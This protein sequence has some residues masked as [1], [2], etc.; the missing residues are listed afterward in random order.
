[1]T[2]I[3]RIG[4]GMLGFLA[5][6]LTVVLGVFR[7]ELSTAYW[8]LGQFDQASEQT[9]ILSSPDSHVHRHVLDGSLTSTIVALQWMLES[10]SFL[11]LAEVEP[12]TWQLRQFILAS[13]QSRFI[14]NHNP[15]S[16]PNSQLLP[17][18]ITD[19]PQ[20]EQYAMI[21]NHNEGQ[22][23]Y[24]L[25]YDG[26]NLERLTPYHDT[27]SPSFVWSSD[28]D[29]LT[30]TATDVQNPPHAIYRQ[31]MD[32][33][34]H[35]ELMRYRGEKRRLIISAETDTI[36]VGHYGSGFDSFDWSAPRLI[37]RISPALSESNLVTPEGDR[38]NVYGQ[39]SQDWIILEK[40]T[41]GGVRENFYRIST[42]GDELAP[43]L[44]N[45]DHR[46]FNSLIFPI[47]DNQAYFINTKNGFDTI[48]QVNLATLERKQLLQDNLFNLI[49]GLRVIQ[50]GKYVIFEGE[51]SDGVGRYRLNLHT[52]ELTKLSNLNDLGGNILLVDDDGVGVLFIEGGSYTKPLTEISRIDLNTNTQELLM[53]FDAIFRG[54]Q[55]N[56]TMRDVDGSVLLSINEA[57]TFNG[58]PE[59]FRINL[60]SG[61]VQ[62]VAYGKYPH[63]SGI[64]DLDWQQTILF[65]ASIAMLAIAAYLSWR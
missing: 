18:S 49:R 56:F 58:S 3:L 24:T 45:D 44:P 15:T 57:A 65:I 51:T 38:Y 42:E 12:D 22:A 28:G 54:F 36:L 17:L 10:K 11:Y 9:L 46:S 7:R 16:D 23:I 53:S 2:F 63:Y 31:R 50:N 43:L 61:E 34:E 39:A 8:V 4:L 48:L 40:L 25:D 35:Q 29:W 6:I 27:I 52:Q 21:L 32:G 14:A 1:M 47:I 59:Q 19:I 33:S 41:S 37:Y 26:E 20:Q 55:F 62:S 30:Y 13:R 5:L 60:D 64:I